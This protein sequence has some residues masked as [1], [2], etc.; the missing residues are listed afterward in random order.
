M[1]WEL[2]KDDDNVIDDDVNDNETCSSTVEIRYRATFRGHNNAYSRQEAGQSLLG[3][4]VFEV[5]WL[6]N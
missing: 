1:V 6:Y 5:A 2:W 3:A 4:T